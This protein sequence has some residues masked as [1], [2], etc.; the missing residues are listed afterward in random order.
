MAD[1]GGGA[2]SAVIAIL[3]ALRRADRTGDGSHCDVSMLDGMLTWMSPHI[4]AARAGS[5][6][7]P[8]AMMLN[9]AHP[10]YH[11]YRCAD[12][13]I[14]VAALEPKFWARL[15]GLLEVE[16]AAR[17][18]L[19]HRRGGRRRRRRLEGVFLG[20]TRAAMARATRRRGRVLR[21]RA[22]HR[23]GAR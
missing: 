5:D 7:G 18:R 8:G 23:R 17:P 3:A 16:D 4:A 14:T 12:G 21:A 10:C 1:I 6:A 15:C 20:A 13:W 11:V 19:R 2:Q 22:H 9:G